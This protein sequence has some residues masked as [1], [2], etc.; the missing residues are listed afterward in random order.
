M[1]I[2]SVEEKYKALM[3]SDDFLGY[4]LVLSR[5][6]CQER[7]DNYL[8]QLY[9][10]TALRQLVRYQEAQEVHTAVLSGCPSEDLLILI[11]TE[12]GYLF[13]DQKDYQ[14]AATYFQKAVDLEPEHAEYNI[15]LGSIFAR[16][17]KFSQAKRCHQVAIQCSKGDIDEAYLNLGYILR[18]EEKYEDALDCFKKSVSIDP[19]YRSAN[20]AIKDINSAIEFHLIQ[21]SIVKR[22]EDEWIH[23]I[24]EADGLPA[25]QLLMSRTMIKE[26]PDCYNA[27]IQYAWILGDL[28]RFKEA[29]DALETAMKYCPDDEMGYVYFSIGCWYELKG[30]YSNAIVWFK[31]AIELESK[32]ANFYNSTGDVLY[33]QENFDEA[34][35]YYERA[36]YCTEGN[37]EEAYYNLGLV[38]RS[39]EKFQ[40]A[41][42][43]F[44]MS[45]ELNPDI[46][47]IRIA[48]SDLQKVI[49]YLAR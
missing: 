19:G 29:H 31:K 33:Q 20:I 3:E 24:L 23:A 1:K 2:L 35:Y 26:Y 42:K 39:E 49:K 16:M 6:L 48:L 25:Y 22:S 8:F 45:L 36:A 28:S 12:M 15:L 43:Y 46:K 27:Y 5:E 34:K 14:Q 10:A 32:N 7:P 18:A 9:Y 44:E 40:E 21:D 4:S 17:G 37:V 47:G 30:D 41:S 11:Y 38:L 13:K